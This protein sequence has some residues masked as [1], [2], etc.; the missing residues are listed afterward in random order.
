[1]TKKLYIIRHGETDYN[2]RGIVQGKGV[3]SSLNETGYSQAQAFFNKYQNIPFDL[4]LTSSLKRTQQTVNPF[5]EKGI[6]HHIHSGLDEIDW[7]IHEGVSPS[8]EH[9]RE[10]HSIISQWNK[11][12]VNITVQNGETPLEVQKRQIEFIE[13]LNNLSYKNALVCTHG[14]ALRILLCTLL[15]KDLHEMDTFPHLNTTLYSL[16]LENNIFKLVDFN[17]TDHLV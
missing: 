14:R 7:G 1:M 13:F 11:G 15:K 16:T 3:D 8:T 6:K 2:K 4:V 10:F 17:N 5:I 12:I 9:R